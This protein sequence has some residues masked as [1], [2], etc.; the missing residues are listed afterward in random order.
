VP[1]SPSSTGSVVISGGLDGRSG[2]YQPQIA[3]LAG[4]SIDYTQRI[5]DTYLPRRAEAALAGMLTWEASGTP[6]GNQ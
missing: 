3:A 2:R 4:W 5:V 6:F 1:S